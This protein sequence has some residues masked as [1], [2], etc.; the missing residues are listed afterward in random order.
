MALD[1]SALLELLGELQSTDVSDR[2]RLA[3]QKLYQ[4]LIDAEA[5][6]F[7]GAAS[8]E[9][10]EGRV[11]V[12][13]GS[14]PRTLTTTAG[15]LDLRIPKLRQGSFFPSL[16]ERR[17]RVDQALF[18]VVMEAYVHGVSTRKVDDLVKALGADSGISKS[19][20]SRICQDLD[21]DVAAFRERPLDAQDYPY[22]FVDATYCKARVGRQVVSQAIV[23]AIGVAADGTRQVLGFDVGD[24]ESEPFWTAFFR[25]LK[26]RGL[27]GVRLVISD[28]HSG[29]IKAIQVAFQGV[30]W[31]RCRV[32]F[33]RNV[34]A[35]V[36]KVAGPMVASIIRTVFVP[37]GKASLVKAQFG[38][39][40]RMLE[41]SHPAIAEMLEDARDEL[42][43]FTGFPAAH[44][45]QIWS[46][47]PLERL[48]KEI[49]RRTDVVGT[50]PNPAALLRLAGH[51]LIEQHD[52][53][54][55]ADR[56]YFSDAS[57]AL[58]NTTGEEDSIPELIAA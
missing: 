47:N 44:W 26:A 32:H 20:V 56:R 35:K 54:D 55:S 3:T 1:Q 15:D 6:A 46:T 31:Q 22:V 52:E 57:M 43:A 27:G 14:R 8:Y 39:V 21:E 34:L 29:L 48:N 19:E 51:V 50:F 58:L 30:S 2:I 53:W 37:R 4:E 12:R 17:R 28:A 11:A 13:N 9:R 45:Q 5:T 38:E 36:P 10:S 41:R 16:L 42:L 40:V 23:V 18:A 49:K 7:I 25:S 24:T 33:M